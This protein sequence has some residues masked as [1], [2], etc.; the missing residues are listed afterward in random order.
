MK[1]LITSLAAVVVLG[2]LSPANPALADGA[3]DCGNIAFGI[4]T[5]IDP[6]DCPSVCTSGRISGK[7]RFKTGTTHFVVASLDTS[8]AIWQYTGQ[9]VITT[10]KGTLTIFSTG[11]LDFTTSPP[12]YNE[13]EVVTGSTGIFAGATSTGLESSGTFDG[14][15]FFGA[16]TGVLCVP[17]DQN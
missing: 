17:P 3:G 7:G 14:S 8:T 10:E 1:K 9:L 2:T 4:Q 11:T 5:T 6:T 12:T 15:S 16:T 13:T